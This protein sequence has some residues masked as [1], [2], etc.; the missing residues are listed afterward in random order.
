MHYSPVGPVTDLGTS[1]ILKDDILKIAGPPDW[2]PAKG[3]PTHIFP[4]AAFLTL[5]ER[6]R[7]VRTLRPLITMSAFETSC[8]IHAL[9]NMG[10]T[11]HACISGSAS[12]PST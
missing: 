12:G 1:C 6:S 3:M 11:E 9:A 8:G 4:W 7:K 10:P 5:G 2:F